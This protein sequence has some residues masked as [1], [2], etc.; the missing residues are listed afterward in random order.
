M[1]WHMSVHT[2]CT[3]LSV[4]GSRGEKNQVLIIHSCSVG[5]IRALS[6]GNKLQ[7]NL[8]IRKL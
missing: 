3:G 1:A 2:E 8:E 6:G 5:R 4:S 7:I